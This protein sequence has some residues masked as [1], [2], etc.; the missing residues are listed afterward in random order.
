MLRTYFEPTELDRSSAL[1]IKTPTLLIAG[2]SSS[3]LYHAII[4]QLEKCVPNSELLTLSGTS[5]GLQTEGSTDL[6]EV[7]LEFL[8]RNEMA[9]KQRRH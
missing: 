3:R 7:V 1:N 5:Y 6:N 9:V 8:S 4:R 2:E